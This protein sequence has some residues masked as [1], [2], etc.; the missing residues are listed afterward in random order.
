MKSSHIIV[1]G[2]TAV[3]IGGSVFAFLR[4]A[5][6]EP[7]PDAADA[8]SASTSPFVHV[9]EL[10][11]HPDDYSGRVFIRGV[12]AGINQEEGVVALIDSRE[13]EECGTVACATTYLPVRVNG[14]LPKALSL[15]QVVGEVTRGANGLEIRADSME[16]VK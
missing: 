3:I 15:V 8:A 2:A 13:F 14:T 12:V 16:G 4:E 11:A 6:T 5:P 9:D 10:A 1:A 7:S